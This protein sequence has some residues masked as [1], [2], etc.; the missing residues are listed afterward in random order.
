MKRLVLVTGSSYCG[1]TM[2]AML[3]GG[4][5]RIAT[6]GE[7]TGLMG[8]VDVHTYR[9]SCG[10]RLRE[11]DFWRDV[12]ADLKRN[13]LKLDLQDFGTSYKPVT[14]N[15]FYRLQYSNLRVNWLEDV[16][17]FIYHLIPKCRH[18]HNEIT[19]RNF[20]I[21]ESILKVSGKDIF[22]DTSKNPNRVKPFS[23]S[24]K[25]KLIVIH[26]IRDGRDV[27][28]STRKHKENVTIAEA[29]RIWKKVNERAARVL[30][31]V[32]SNRRCVVRYEDLAADPAG[33]LER[34]CRLIG[35]EYEPSCLKLCPTN[36]HIMGN[37]G[38]RLGDKKKVENPMSGG[39]RI[40]QE[41]VSIF[42]RRAGSINRRYG[43]D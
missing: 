22:V 32:P 7:M 19:N 43:Y 4:H 39:K 25:D 40:L 10:M 9:C 11:C 35:V 29:I 24:L 21:A 37:T 14:R 17:D 27:V 16:R 38:A 36:Q 3:L 28:M 18:H 13:G 20:A 23:H 33:T 5:S 34:L 41:E 30:N 2:L 8:R 1:S 15:L 6:I 26:L 31:Y 12:R 42:E